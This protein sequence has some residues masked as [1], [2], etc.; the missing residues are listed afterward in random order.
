[1]ALIVIQDATSTKLGVF[2][3]V[4]EDLKDLSENSLATAVLRVDNVDVTD[5]HIHDVLSDFDETF[6]VKFNEDKTV[7]VW[8]DGIQTGAHYTFMLV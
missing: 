6:G 5:S 8:I 4:F 2:K 1:M 3:Y 7:G